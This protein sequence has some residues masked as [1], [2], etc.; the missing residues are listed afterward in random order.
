MR[1]RDRAPTLRC[2]ERCIAQCPHL[3]DAADGGELDAG[4]AGLEQP[5]DEA[6][7]NLG[8]PHKRTANPS[9][10]PWRTSRQDVRLRER[11]ECSWSTDAEIERRST[12]IDRL[13][14]RQLHERADASGRLT[15]PRSIVG[16][17]LTS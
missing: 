7:V 1:E 3:C 15:A 6:A 10:A 11:S 17:Y 16:R 8:Y 9:A 5:V 13:E 4:G 14:R 12:E 2:V